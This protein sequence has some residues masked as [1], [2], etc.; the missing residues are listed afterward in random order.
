MI[1]EYSVEVVQERNSYA[2]SVWRR[3]KMKLDGR[4]LDPSK[5]MSVTDQVLQ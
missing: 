2:V 4:E 1:N 5:K 3:V